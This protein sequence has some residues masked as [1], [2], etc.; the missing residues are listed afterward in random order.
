MKKEEVEG[1]LNFFEDI[2]RLKR[3]P[4]SGWWYYGVISPESVADHSFAVVTLSYLLATVI[5]ESNTLRGKL[6]VFKIVKMAILHELGET[7]I[8]DLQLEARRFLGEEYVKMAELK[9]V[10]ET[11]RGLGKLGEELRS[12]YKE[13]IEEKS[14]EAK[15][16][17]LVDKLELLVQASLYHKYGH[18]NLNSILEG[19]KRLIEKFP[20]PIVE[21]IL[22]EIWS[23][24]K[25]YDD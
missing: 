9:V 14:P 8:G 20:H 11:T 21:M 12:I 15:L 17:H 5:N 16:A 10:Q 22:E 4:R 13:F 25:T 19:Q 3:V 7:R 6:D 23:F 24:N 1:F 2:E 18:R